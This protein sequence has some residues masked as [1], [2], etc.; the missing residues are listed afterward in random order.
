MWKLLIDYSGGSNFVE[1]ASASDV[2]YT[3]SGYIGVVCI[4][5]SSNANKFFFDDF[6]INQF[7]VPDATPPTIEVVSVQ[8]A[9]HLS[10]FFSEAVEQGSAEMI[11]NYHVSNGMGNPAAAT[12]Q[13]DTRTVVLAFPQDFPNGIARSIDVSGV[14]DVAGNTMVSAQK[15]FM[16]FNAVPAMPNDIIITE[17]FADP[18]PSVGLPEVEFLEIYNRSTNPFN[19]NGW[20]ITDGSSTGTLGSFILLPS[21]Y[22]ILAPQSAASLFNPYGNVL[23]LAIFPTLNNSG[24]AMTLLDPGGAVINAVHYYST[25]Y[26]DV[27]KQG[28]GYSLERI[29]PEDFCLESENW[30]A[31]N[32]PT[33]GTPGTQNSVF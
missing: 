23:G 32:N 6:S 28:G 24:D 25:W 17:I 21:Q 33:G 1:E 18:S 4:Y 13:P 22:L 31:S 5:T 10:I 27:D 14:R 19:V 30:I 2:T 11:L 12:L 15:E 16:Y 20:K 9:N 26:G 7:V 3:T 29:D 8:S